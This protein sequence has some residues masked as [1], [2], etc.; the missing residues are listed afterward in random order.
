M[1]IVKD[2]DGWYNTYYYKLH[3]GILKLANKFNLVYKNK[4]T[5]EYDELLKEFIT[6]NV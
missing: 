1:T 5:T 2:V 6:E 3:V 4:H